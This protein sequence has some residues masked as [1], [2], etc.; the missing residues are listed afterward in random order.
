MV[1]MSHIRPS[2]RLRPQMVQ[3]AV[4]AVGMPAMAVDILIE[5]TRKVARESGK[6]LDEGMDNAALPCSIHCLLIMDMDKNIPF[7]F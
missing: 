7:R 1:V 3:I 5:I 2:D 6:P 4:N